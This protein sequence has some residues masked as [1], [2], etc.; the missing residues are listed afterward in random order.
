MPKA[1]KPRLP[2]VS[3]PFGRWRIAVFIILLLAFPLPAF[4]QEPIE[5]IHKEPDLERS[6]LHLLLITQQVSVLQQEIQELQKQPLS[7]SASRK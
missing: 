7:E 3:R 5:D 4:A 6:W 1:S 2:S